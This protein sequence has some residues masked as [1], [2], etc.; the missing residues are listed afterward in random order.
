MYVEEIEAFLDAVEG[1]REYPKT[2]QDE[3][4]IIDTL[5]QLAADHGNG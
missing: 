5:Y 1:R 2:F 3:K 4:A